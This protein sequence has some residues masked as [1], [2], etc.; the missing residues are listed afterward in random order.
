MAN[1]LYS[2]NAITLEISLIGRMN[3]GGTR[4]WNDANPLAYDSDTDTLYTVVT[5]WNSYPNGPFWGQLGRVNV[6]NAEVTII[7]NI[8]PGI[9]GS[10]SYNEEDKQLYGLVVYGS[11]SWDSPYKT[12][13]IRINPTDAS[14]DTLFE[15]PYHT[16]LGF[17]QKPGENIYYSWINWTTHFYGKVNLN[18]QTIKQLG[19]SDPVD[20][21]AAMV[22]K[23]FFLKS[24]TVAIKPRGDNNI[25][26]KSNAKIPVAVLSTKDF[27]AYNQVDP[28]SL[29]FGR[30][31][32]EASLAYCDRPRDVNGDGLKDLVCHFYSRDTDFQCGDTWGIL[33]GETLQGTPIEGIDSVKIKP[34]PEKETK[35]HSWKAG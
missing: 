33:K 16:M 17:A 34:C 27:N 9:V 1:N 19:N 8:I 28:D 23:D 21:I 10:L 30:T 20:V 25:N 2:I 3:I 31:G 24:A 29:T 26:L 32:D 7:G 35:P 14:V 11:G 18:T 6:S 13:V 4:P 12:N 15:T 22:Y 5:Y